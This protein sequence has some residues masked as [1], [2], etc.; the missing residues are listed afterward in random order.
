MFAALL[1]LCFPHRRKKRNP[2][3]CR[4]GVSKGPACNGPDS[5][6][7]RTG[8]KCDLLRHKDRPQ[9]PRPTSGA[10]MRSLSSFPSTYY[11]VPRAPCQGSL[12]LV[13]TSIG[14]VSSPFR[15]SGT[16]GSGLE[17]RGLPVWMT[18]AEVIRVWKGLP[19]AMRL[20]LILRAECAWEYHRMSDQM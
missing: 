9:G 15:M 18:H 13:A 20:I 1:W 6:P 4:Q 19:V 16:L 5:C 7:P 14:P 11:V 3:P 8:R 10:A 17:R 2:V 12:P